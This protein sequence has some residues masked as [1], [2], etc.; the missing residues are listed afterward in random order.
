[1]HCNKWGQNVLDATKNLLVALELSEQSIRRG[2]RGRLFH[3]LKRFC[4]SVLAGTSLCMNASLRMYRLLFFMLDWAYQA[5]KRTSINRVGEVP[6][7]HRRYE[8]R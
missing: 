7:E 5:H 2:Y 8:M 3:R 1:M 4:R 6:G